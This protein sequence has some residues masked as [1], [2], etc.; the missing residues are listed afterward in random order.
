METK[1]HYSYSISLLRIFSM[2]CIIVCHIASR[3]N[4]T[5]IAQFFNVGVPI[6]A[7]I[8]G[9]LYGSK[10]FTGSW[11]WLGKRYIRLAM[12]LLAWAIVY[13][14]M[15]FTKQLPPRMVSVSVRSI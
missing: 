10:S 11:S 14:I 13:T 9:Y 12:P 8:S 4:H 15:A 5:A 7:L 6:F 3:R 2:L 1:K